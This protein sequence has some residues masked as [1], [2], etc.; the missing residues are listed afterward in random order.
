MRLALDTNVLAYAEGVNGTA[1]QDPALRIIS[2]LPAGEAFLPVQ[3]IGELFYLLVRKA[4]RSAPQA[5]S[6][7]L[8]WQDAFLLI[9]TSRNVTLAAVD[10]ASRHRFK[11][12]DA[13]M[14][15]AASS[16][17]CRLL[18][19]EDLQHGFTWNGVTVVNPFSKTPHA[20]LAEALNL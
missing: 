17:G 4:G 3:A 18:L 11:I 7:L 5:R 20:L 14:L 19:S 9:E 10:L 8:I 15:S 2:R 13:V 16:V 1:M 6:A 12:W